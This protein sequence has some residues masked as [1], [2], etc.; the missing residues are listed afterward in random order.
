[1]TSYWSE[2]KGLSELDRGTVEGRRG[3]VVI[4]GC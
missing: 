1:M 4:L 2:V 3:V